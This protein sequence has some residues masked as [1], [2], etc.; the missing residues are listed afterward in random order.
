MIA[1][2]AVRPLPGQTN[3]GDACRWWQAG[4]L[5]VACI[6]DGLGHGEA[7]E[8]AA[9]R[10]LVLADSCLSLPPH[11]MLRII[12]RGLTE[13]RG[14]ACGVAQVD[15]HSKLLRYSAI[16]N[17]RGVLFCAA[18]RYLDAAPGIVGTGACVSS[19][20]EVPWTPGDLLALWTDGMSGNLNLD[21]QSRHLLGA[22]K[23]LAELL[24]DRFASQN[25][26]ALVLC[27]FLDDNKA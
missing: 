11:E 6:V 22:P 1:G 16:G 3:C 19:V 21:R 26:D 25:D 8:V 7:A 5:W 9:Q 2:C 14:A 20:V 15:S 10:A 24:L 12:D 17:I 27:C 4:A 13:T 18:A 23:Q